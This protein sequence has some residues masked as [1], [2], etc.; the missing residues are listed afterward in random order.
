MNKEQEI[1]AGQ[2]LIM[3]RMSELF[4]QM[5]ENA[6]SEEDMSRFFV[7]PE[8]PTKE[9]SARY[10]KALDKRQDPYRDQL[11]D[12][13]GQLFGISGGAVERPELDAA[14]ADELDD[15]ELMSHAFPDFEPWKEPERLK[16][17]SPI[18]R[19]V[20]VV[21][22]F[23]IEF[24]EGGLCGYIENDGWHT[25]P[26]LEEAFGLLGVPQVWAVISKF[27][28]DSKLTVSD[29]IFLSGNDY[30][31]RMYD[32]TAVDEA[33]GALDSRHRLDALCAALMRSH[34]DEFV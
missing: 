2:K 7:D 1:K 30:L 18:R 5:V 29:L 9:E 19:A 14:A 12:L 15:E 3:S 22:S 11:S 27:F 16:T 17:L 26:H 13:M 24:D 21:H 31:Y 33:V 10:E 25:A 23:V 28:E 6:A 20:Y 32:F 8:N 34:I 4:G